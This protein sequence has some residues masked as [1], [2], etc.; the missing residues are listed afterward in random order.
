MDSRTS[1]LADVLERVLDNGVVIVGDI[2]VDVVDIELLTLRQR[3]FVASARAARETG[4][5]WWTGDPF[6]AP[7]NGCTQPHTPL[8]APPHEQ[9]PEGD[10]LIFTLPQG[11][12]SFGVSAGQVWDEGC[13]HDR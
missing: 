8:H 7:C 5:D 13:G 11:S 12:D 10:P 9:F 1:A 3:L 4:T 2:A 6:F